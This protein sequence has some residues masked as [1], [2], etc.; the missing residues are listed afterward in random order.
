MGITI[1]V[2]DG[3]HGRAAEGMAVRLSQEVSGAW[4]LA[5]GGSADDHGVVPKVSTPLRGR[6][7][8]EVDLDRYYPALGMEPTVCRA[9]VTFR[10]FHPDERVSLLVVVTPSTVLVIRRGAY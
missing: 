9:T 6:Y 4:V 5:G 1:E 10:V 7:Q 3:I 8:L 2:V